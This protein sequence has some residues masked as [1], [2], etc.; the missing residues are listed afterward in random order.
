[1]GS[2]ARIGVDYVLTDKNSYF[3]FGALINSDGILHVEDGMDTIAMKKTHRGNEK[4]WDFFG[5]KLSGECS[6]VT[7]TPKNLYLV[8]HRTNRY[9]NPSNDEYT[10]YR[11][12]KMDGKYKKLYQWKGENCYLRSVF[13]PS[14]N[15]G[16]VFYES[17]G[18]PD[19]SQLYWTNDGGKHW[20]YRNLNRPVGKTHLYQKKLY[21]LSYEYHLHNRIYSMQMDGSQ[22]DSL[23]F[24]LDIKDFAVD[25]KGF[26]LFGQDTTRTK[27]G[28]W[29]YDNKNGKLSTVKIFISD[30]E[31][32]FPSGIYK[33]NNL[34]V[35][36][37]EKIDKGMLLGLGG[38]RPYMFVSK[39]NGKT[40][41]KF[42]S[43]NVCS[44]NKRAFYKDKRMMA[45]IMPGE[46][47]ICNFE[48]K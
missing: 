43:S 32:F 44:L 36:I 18:N 35:I 16:V 5:P 15:Q 29:Y 37:I 25:D 17:S 1:M 42:Y 9:H 46:I 10:L 30:N 19:D 20:Q 38:T 39:D 8:G 28:L 7:Q 4:K 31:D 23:Q 41:N 26:W 34:I 12:S 27:T 47:F 22:M 45:Y 33:Y 21:F 48:K 13:F 6:Y 24:D 11:I 40:W 14:D 2:K 3:A